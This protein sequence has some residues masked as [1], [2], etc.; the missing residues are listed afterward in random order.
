MTLR[1]Q[2]MFAS[3]INQYQLNLVNIYVISLVLSL[4]FVRYQCQVGKENHYFILAMEN[5]GLR[6]LF[7]DY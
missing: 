6:C 3:L 1:T 4:A 5:V 2:V 7:Y